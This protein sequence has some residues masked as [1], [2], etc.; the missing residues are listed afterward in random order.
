MG[1]R[2]R[3]KELK[4]V[5]FYSRR[6]PSTPW[7]VQ[8]GVADMEIL[9]ECPKGDTQWNSTFGGHPPPTST[10]GGQKRTMVHP[11]LLAG[12]EPNVF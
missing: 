4:V 1:I 5:S 8:S 10:L 3:I 2:V 11:I 9:T 6:L 12:S 7:W